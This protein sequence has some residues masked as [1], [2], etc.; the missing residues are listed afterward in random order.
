[1]I[2]VNVEIPIM[3]QNYD[4]QLDENVPLFEIQEEI[5]EMIC[6]RE[7]C[8]L[9]GMEH[10][11][12]LWDKKRGLILRREESARDNGLETGSELLMA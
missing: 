2:I 10:R 3:G 1:M 4:F 9:D 11:F 12:L 6:R 5:T 8:R 7:Q